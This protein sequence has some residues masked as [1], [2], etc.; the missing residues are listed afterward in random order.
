[1]TLCQCH[2]ITPSDLY[3]PSRGVGLTT[4]QQQPKYFLSL[5]VL[6]VECISFI[7]CIMY[8]SSSHWTL[9][10]QTS[11][12]LVQYVVLYYIYP[13][14]LRYFTA[15]RYISILLWDEAELFVWHH[16]WFDYLCNVNITWSATSCSGLRWSATSCSGLRWSA[17]S[18][19][20]LRWSATSCSGL[21]CW[22]CRHCYCPCPCCH[23]YRYYIRQRSWANVMYSSLFVCL[24]V[25][26]FVC[27]FVC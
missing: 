21:R 6:N 13:W 20:G 24:S 27:L 16:R 17:T 25:C 23:R 22:G 26:L 3:S 19:S 1:M 4:K 2:V 7:T 18:C 8:I 12:P 14:N 9:W 15:S 10:Y 5:F 11:R